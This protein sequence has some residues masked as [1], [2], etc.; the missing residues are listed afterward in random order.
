MR[1]FKLG[2]LQTGYV[3]ELLLVSNI[4]EDLKE[5]SF[6]EEQII[7]HLL[8]DN[9]VE[10]INRCKNG[11]LIK[12]TYIEKYQTHNKVN[13]LLKNIIKNDDNLLTKIK[14]YFNRMTDMEQIYEELSTQI[15]L[16]T[17]T[18]NIHLEELDNTLNS[19]FKKNRLN[20]AETGI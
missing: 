14:S 19:F 17:E 12:N 20:S 18:S 1:K 4:I 2:T 11:Q 13:E 6:T 7:Y 3:E 8:N 15:Q 10:L 5:Q 9:Y 16:Y